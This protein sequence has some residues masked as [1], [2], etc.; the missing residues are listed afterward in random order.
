MQ[1]DPVGLSFLQ[2]P[3]RRQMDCGFTI[4]T[5]NA[6]AKTRENRAI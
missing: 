2:V 6:K 1:S 5:L 3:P 4:A